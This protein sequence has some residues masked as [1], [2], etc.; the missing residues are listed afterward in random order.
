MHKNP[1][2]KKRYGQHFLKNNFIAEKIVQSLDV[3][4]S[5]DKV[6]EI[7]PGPGVLTK[8]LYALLS[9]RF[10]AVEIDKDMVELLVKKNVLP[11]NQIIE[12]DI[13]KL[14]LESLPFWN[15]SVQLGVIGNFPYNI[16]SQILFKVVEY[17]NH[18]AEV[19][20]MFQK[21]VA[22][23]VCSEPGSKQYG[24]LSVL[25][26]VYYDR[27]VLFN[28]PPED[29]DPPPKVDSAVIKLTRKK[30]SLVVQDFDKLRTIVKKAFGQR[31]K[32]IRNSLQQYIKGQVGIEKYTNKRPEEMH[33]TEFI[34]LTHLLL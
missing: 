13:L 19:V 2:A 6:L 14:E 26:E 33:A 4:Q 8:E 34:E 7:G 32:K 24:I 28:V 29:F 21:E 15:P 20:G 5:I 16:S 3:N 18:I 11:K 23:R 27:Q 9:D 31:R 30:E 22:H 1:R 12:F 25:L 17:Q 10:L